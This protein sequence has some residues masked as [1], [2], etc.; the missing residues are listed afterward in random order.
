MEIIGRIAAPVFG[1]VALVHLLSCLLHRD[2][3]RKATKVFLVPLII[4]I[5]IGVCGFAHPLVLTALAFGFVGDVLLIPGKNRICFGLGG[6]SFLIGHVFYIV[7]ALRTGIPQATFA[8][9]GVLSIAA[10]ALVTVVFCLLAYRAFARKL[11]VKLR[12]PVIIYMVAVAAMAAVMVYM[13]PGGGFS[14]PVLMLAVGGAHFAASDFMLCA[15]SLRAV[16]IKNNR[17]AVMMTY[18]IAQFFLA[19]G[20]ALL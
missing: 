16:K 19:L 11:P 1:A 6:F 12:V 10:A 17:F 13:M 9:L 2:G 18:I 4:C 7:H 8:R 20:F 14:I 5:H 15:G 3:I